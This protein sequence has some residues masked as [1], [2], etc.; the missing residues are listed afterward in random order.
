MK[1]KTFHFFASSI[2]EFKVNT[3]LKALIKA[4]D[5]N[6]LEYGIWYV[7]ADVNDDY[8]IESYAPQV[9]GVIYLGKYQPK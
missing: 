5:A 4:M 1:I 6:G 9:A 7:P 2:G 8:E 3:D